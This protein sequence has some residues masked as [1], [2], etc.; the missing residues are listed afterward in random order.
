VGVGVQAV[1]D[2]DVWLNVLQYAVPLAAVAWAMSR[3]FRQ[4]SSRFLSLNTPAGLIPAP[5]AA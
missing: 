1:C 3:V 5:R 4:K 2:D